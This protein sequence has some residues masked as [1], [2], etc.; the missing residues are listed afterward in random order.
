MDMEG[1][2]MSSAEM[3]HFSMASMQYSNLPKFESTL[4]VPKVNLMPRDLALRIMS[5]L[6]IL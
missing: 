4:L 5:R 1:N 2:H 3:P 6:G